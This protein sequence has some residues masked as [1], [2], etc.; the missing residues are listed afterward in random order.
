MAT[1]QATAQEFME[2]VKAKAKELGVQPNDLMGEL[3]LICP[4]RRGRPPKT[5]IS[6]EPAMTKRNY[7][8]MR[9]TTPACE[10]D[11]GTTQV[12]PRDRTWIVVQVAAKAGSTKKM[13][14]L[15]SVSKITIS[16]A[17][18]DVAHFQLT[19]VPVDYEN[20]C[21][22]CDGNF[23][24]PEC[25]E[26]YRFSISLASISPWRSSP[27]QKQRAYRVHQEEHELEMAANKTETCALP[28]MEIY[29]DTVD[30]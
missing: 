18:D 22:V 12:D 8:K 5:E 24:S 14:K 26:S 20:P 17:N 28:G 10:C 16:P 9:P 29:I 11:I 1:I 2:V 15:T 3:T 7:T 6:T 13:W 4:K 23:C 30:E 21:Q 27:I 19:E 25:E